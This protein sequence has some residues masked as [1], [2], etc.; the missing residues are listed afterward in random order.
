MGCCTSLDCF[1][2]V[3]G[4]AGLMYDVKVLPRGVRLTFG[5]Y[6]A[7]LK[8]FAAYITKKLTKD[9]GDVL[10]KDDT[11]FGRYKDQIMRALSAFDVKQPYMHASYYAQLTLQPRR[12]Q[13]SN[14]D[15]RDA[16][17]KITLPDLVSYMKRLF[18]SGK[19]EALVQGN[20]DVKEAL[21]L[22][23]IVED[24]IHF[25]PI[26]SSEYPPRLEALPLPP[27]SF[28]TLPVRLLIAEPNPFNENSVAYVLLQSL[29][30]SEQDHVMLELVSAIVEEP[31]Y[32]DLR[33][34]KQLGYIVSSGIRGIGDTRTL[35]F[36]VQSS[37]ATA[38]DLAIEILAFLDAVQDGILVKLS[39]GDLAVYAK[40]LIDRKTEPD[41]DLIAE[42]TRNWSEIASGRFQFD[43]IQ[44]EAAALLDVNKES[45]LQFWKTIYAGDGRRVL[46]SEVI[47]RRG[48]AASDLPPTTF[49]YSTSDLMRDELTLGIDDLEQFRRD[50]EKLLATPVAALA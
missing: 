17:R 31:F 50:R 11:D 13:Y 39:K 7:K 38:D 18:S 49:R 9:I 16:T 45:L 23:E 14:A 21:D 41:K 48:A 32:N 3:A 25:K 36:V 29:G 44:R 12:F 15:L 42:V 43:R 37:V 10:P 27:S 26:P 6:N 1:L 24:A 33:T 8:D 46:V 2:L 4:L 34:K 47:P 40:S 35:A 30:L 22:V 19:G 20:L 28:V 5:G